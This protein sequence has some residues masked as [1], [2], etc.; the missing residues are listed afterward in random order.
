MNLDILTKEL[1]KFIE[2]LRFAGYQIG[3]AQYIAAQDLILTLA[4]QGKLP[5]ELTE[6]RLFLAPILCHSPKEQ[7]EF[8]T[9]FNQWVN[10]F[11]QTKILLSPETK[12]SPKTQITPEIKTT[13]NI[14]ASPSSDVESE[15][16]TIKKG[17]TLW[18]WAFIAFAM[19]FLLSI[20]FMWVNR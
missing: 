20:W 1:I 9:H 6:L 4:A 2:K 7:I 13:T 14:K 18:K 12:T 8:E 19:V 16:R 17:N 5:S 3:E 15:L 10:Q 11:P